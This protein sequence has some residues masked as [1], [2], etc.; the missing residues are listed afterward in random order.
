MRGRQKKKHQGEGRLS[1]KKEIKKLYKAEEKN[2]H[3]FI[4]GKQ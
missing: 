3:F 4:G 1:R 2:P